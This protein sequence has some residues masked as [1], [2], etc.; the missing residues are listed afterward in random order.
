MFRALQLSISD[1]RYT[2]DSKQRYVISIWY[3][4]CIYCEKCRHIILFVYLTFCVSDYPIPHPAGQYPAQDQAKHLAT[5]YH[6]SH[7]TQS[8]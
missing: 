7:I 4:M 1:H 6:V 8:G 3:L 5:G 2:A